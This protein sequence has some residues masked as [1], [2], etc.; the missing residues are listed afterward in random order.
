MPIGTEQEFMAGG[1]VGSA[2]GTG[3]NLPQ[4]KAVRLMPQSYHRNR[5]RFKIELLHHAVMTTANIIPVSV[6]N[7]VTLEIAEKS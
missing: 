1:L 2:S 5:R 3:K 6:T 7:D 4:T